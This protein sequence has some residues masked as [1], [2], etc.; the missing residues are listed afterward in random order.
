MMAPRTPNGLSPRT[1]PVQLHPEEEQQPPFRSVTERFCD[2]MSRYL[3]YLKDSETGK[4]DLATDLAWI[5][6]HVQMWTA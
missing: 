3:R 2:K 1:P 4:P 5:M 6:D